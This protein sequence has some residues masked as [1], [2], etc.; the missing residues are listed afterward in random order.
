[1]AGN[2]REAENEISNLPGKKPKGSKVSFV[3]FINQYS[4]ENTRKTWNTDFIIVCHNLI[5][6]F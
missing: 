2:K 3:S 6:L 4:L 5:G 1:M